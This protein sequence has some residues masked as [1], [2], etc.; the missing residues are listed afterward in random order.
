MGTR[1]GNNNGSCSSNGRA[2]STNNRSLQQA[3]AV[4]MGTS[5]RNV[6][7]LDIKKAS[8]WGQM[9]IS[10]VHRARNFSVVYERA[11]TSFG[12]AWSSLF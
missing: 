2:F 6:R 8:V 9:G 12:V 3:K 1:R 11:I 5:N 7:L 4:A 10:L